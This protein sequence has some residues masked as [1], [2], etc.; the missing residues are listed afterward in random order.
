MNLY[1]GSHPVRLPLLLLQLETDEAV[2][3]AAAEAA[4]SCAYTREMR[5]APGAP[6]AVGGLSSLYILSRCIDSC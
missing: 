1:Y 4:D 6:A 5:E 3:V 2:C